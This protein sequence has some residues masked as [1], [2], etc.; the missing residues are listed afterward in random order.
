MTWN[1]LEEIKSPTWRELTAIKF[2]ILSF[3]PLISSKS[4]YWFSD[5]Q[6]AVHIV[7]NGSRKK[8]LQYLAVGIF[9]L[10]VERHFNYSGLDTSVRK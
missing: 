1:T 4:L 10:F 5:N 8:H 7:T 2:G 9:K 6:A 3:L